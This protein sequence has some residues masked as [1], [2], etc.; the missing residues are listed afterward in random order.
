MEKCR[1]CLRKQNQTGSG[2]RRLEVRDA[3][4]RAYT[5]LEM[6]LRMLLGL[7]P[8]KAWRVAQILHRTI[9]PVSEKGSERR[10][11]LKKGFAYSAAV[12]AWLYLG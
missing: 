3:T 5:G 2:S 7:G 8:R 10:Q 4:V 6:R 9:R 11:I 1:T 12:A